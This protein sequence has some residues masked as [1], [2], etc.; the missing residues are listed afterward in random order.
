MGNLELGVRDLVGYDVKSR[1]ILF[2]SLPNYS[3]GFQVF[4]L[5]EKE[6]YFRT[7]SPVFWQD[8]YA[9]HSG[10]RRKVTMPKFTS[11]SLRSFRSEN[12]RLLLSGQISPILGKLN[13]DSVTILGE[14]K[15]GIFSELK[16]VDSQFSAGTSTSYYSTS[17]TELAG[18]GNRKKVSVSRGSTCLASSSEVLLLRDALGGRSFI[19]TRG[20]K[21]GAPRGVVRSAKG[22][23]K[24]IWILSFNAKKDESFI[25]YRDLKRSLVRKSAG[26]ANVVKV[27]CS[28]NEFFVVEIL[29]SGKG[30]M[31]RASVA[32]DHL[33][34]SKCEFGFELPND[35]D[36]IIVGI[37]YV[38]VLDSAGRLHTFRLSQFSP[39]K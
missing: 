33:A 22:A 21:I 14:L 26:F 7:G 25:E 16:R 36:S 4:G 32:D 23:D 5:S 13:S 11:Q 2:P 20:K 35:Y 9:D 38:R 15:A 19:D 24:G 29:E 1:K 28:G 37:G 17:P 27:L 34:L 30:V 12:G 8:L 10:T 6:I 3:K 31:W 18:V 39:L